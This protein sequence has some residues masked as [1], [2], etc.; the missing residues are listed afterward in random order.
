MFS[1]SSND[2]NKIFPLKLSRQ[3]VPYILKPIKIHTRPLVAVRT[4]A[5]D[6]RLDIHRNKIY[7][8]LLDSDVSLKQINIS[9]GRSNY[10]MFNKLFRLKFQTS[11][12]SESYMC[13]ICHGGDSVDDLLMPCRCRGTVA[14][15]HLKCLE[16]WLMES[17]RS[18]CELCQ[19]HYEV[20]RQPR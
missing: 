2:S 8:S 19:H 14:L 4:L 10:I 3:S 12:D 13:R 20:V 17:S 9:Y 18:Y 15:V 11:L 6:D 7:V 1:A 16:R 5:H